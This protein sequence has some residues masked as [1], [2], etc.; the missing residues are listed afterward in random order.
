MHWN[1]MFV[2]TGLK[3]IFYTGLKQFCLQFSG[4]TVQPFNH[5]TLPGDHGKHMKLQLYW[6]TCNTQDVRYKM[7]IKNAIA[8]G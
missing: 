4:T 6:K 8:G 3:I 1:F 5:H 7:N 2:E